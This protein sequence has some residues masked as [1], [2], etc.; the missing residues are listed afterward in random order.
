MK[1]ERRASIYLRGGSRK[2]LEGTP[3]AKERSSLDRVKVEFGSSWVWWLWDIQMET[4][5]KQFGIFEGDRTNKIGNSNDLCMPVILAL[6]RL[7]QERKR[8]NKR[9]QQQLV[10][11]WWTDANWIA[12]WRNGSGQFILKIC[13]KG[14][15]YLL[16]HFKT[17]HTQRSNHFLF[18]EII[19][20]F[21]HFPP[22]LFPPQSLCMP[23]CSQIH[24]F[25]IFNYYCMC[26]YVFL[27]T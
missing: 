16:T 13:T 17:Q 10:C 6:E 18:F 26:V 21:R 15:R 19:T 5:K 23:A 11:V 25:F 12:Q 24:D 9:L 14:N 3:A 1:L 22:S 20:Q 27:N 7:K 8:I 2:V 4:L